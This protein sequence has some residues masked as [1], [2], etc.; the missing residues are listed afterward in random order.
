LVLLLAQILAVALGDPAKADREQCGD[1]RDKRYQ[2]E[3]TPTTQITPSATT[4]AAR[5]APLEMRTA[6]ASASTYT[7]MKQ[8]DVALTSA[9]AE[10]TPAT[11]AARMT[12]VVSASAA[13]GRRGTLRSESPPSQ[14]GN[15]PACASDAVSFA[16]PAV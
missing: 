4:A 6:D 2:D 16:V 5:S 3:N 1:A 15:A 12:V 13:S 14:R 11:R 10:M 8:A 7:R 9:A